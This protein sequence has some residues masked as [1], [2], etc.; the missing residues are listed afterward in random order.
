MDAPTLMMD[1]DI[2]ELRKLVMGIWLP[3]IQQD[4]QRK[5]LRGIEEIREINYEIWEI[6]SFL[7]LF[8][9]KSRSTIVLI[10]V[11]CMW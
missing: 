5:V 10:R 4:Y 8:W 2:M 7:M 6:I 3:F 9:M 11:K 1:W